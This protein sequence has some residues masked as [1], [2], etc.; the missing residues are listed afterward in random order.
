MRKIKKGSTDRSIILRAIDSTDG[1]PETGI[2]YDTPGID[3]WYRRNGGAVV[4][5]TEV[6][7]AAV[8]SAHA[9]GG[10]IHIG[11]GYF[12]LDS[13]DAAFAT[14]A[15]SVM[16]GGTATGMI[17]IGAEI[18]LVNYDPEDTIRLGLTALPAAAADA[19][20][21][22][23]ISDAGG[24]DL[25]T[26][27]KR[28]VISV[29]PQ[30]PV[31]DLAN[32]VTNRL[33][34]SFI[35]NRGALP[36]TA[37]ITS[38]SYYIYRK[39]KGGTSW[40]LVVSGASSETEGSIY[41][42]SFLITSANYSE[43]DS[44]QIYFTN[45]SIAIDGITYAIAP[46]TGLFFQTYIRETGVKEMYA[47]LPDDNIMGSSVKTDKDDEIDSI[48]SYVQNIQ[49]TGSPAYDAASSYTLTTGTQTSGTYVN[50]DSPNGVYHVHTD[51]GGVLDLYYEYIL[52]GDEV[53]SAFV[54][55]GRINSSNDSVYIQVY[56]WVNSAWVLFHTLA[57]VNTTVDTNLSPALVAKYTGTE[58]N[59]GKVRIR[60]VNAVALTTATLYIDQLIVAKSMTS[61]TVGY[62]LGA[63]WVDTIDGYTGTTNF[64]HG[65]AD[66]P[67]KTFL[68]AVTIAA[69]MHMRRFEMVSG[70]EITLIADRERYSMRGDLWYLDPAGYSLNLSYI[71][72]ALLGTSAQTS[73]TAASNVV[74]ENCS[75]WSVILDSCFGERCT[76]RGPLVL[77]S[78]AVCIFRN[79]AT[80]CQY[81]DYIDIDYNS[82]GDS[83]FGI[84]NADCS[85]EIK[86]MVAGNVLYF[87]GRGRILIDSSCT[88]GTMFLCGNI[89]YSGD[90][91]N[92]ITKTQTTR[93]ALDRIIADQ[94]AFNGA[95]IALIKSGVAAIP[96]NPMLDSEDGSSFSDIG[97]T[98]LDN[99]DAT[100]SSRAVAGDEMNIVDGGITAA[101]F[102]ESTAF[103][104]ASA[105]TGST[106]VARTG[107]DSDTLK[108]LSD[109]IDA[110][111]SSGS[112]NV[113]EAII[114]GL[115][116]AF[117][118]ERILDDLINMYNKRLELYTYTLQQLKYAREHKDELGL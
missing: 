34:L 58:D 36:T 84:V 19:A 92:L 45:I 7:L 100:I 25:D 101:K 1:T 20:G 5:I 35:T 15:D 85:V 63:V 65:V 23:P 10:V 8:D 13:P 90:A 111:A 116:A 26:Y 29:I 17:I 64:I 59:V 47:K 67:S 37:E 71:N 69:S 114:E 74:F 93:F 27:V 53:A 41:I 51:V 118:N 86:N 73:F 96:T 81:D 75:F 44:L 49:I 57:G 113:D 79:P 24:L 32:T 88:G 42:P 55:K 54:F 61:R 14:G 89:S 82:T 106:Q 60:F 103:P 18:Q 11:N 94:T 50:T 91:E 83:Q 70:S 87:A 22:L 105:D 62:A 38:G 80:L 52:R 115:Y 78:G 117:N 31:L 9:D 108:T 56:D 110:I 66:R 4:S 21:G 12:R 109:Q 33:G 40:S 46:A 112:V 102:D 6:T 48:L 39:A 3:L 77:A 2:A 107:A 104:L 16:F 98:R 76:L 43:G 28:Y 72:G 68:E 97:D 95:D 30:I 99:L